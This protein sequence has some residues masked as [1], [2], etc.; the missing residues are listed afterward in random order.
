MSLH[1]RAAQI[2]KEIREEVKQGRD[3]R[4]PH[5][6]YDLDPTVSA[7][8]ASMATW[9]SDLEA[10]IAKKTAPKK[11]MTQTDCDLA[12]MTEERD[13]YAQMY[14]ATEVDL[15]KVKEELDV[16]TTEW[17]NHLRQIQVEKYEWKKKAEAYVTQRD[18][19]RRDLLLYTNVSREKEQRLKRAI[20]EYINKARG[21][22]EGTD[23]DDSLASED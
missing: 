6:Q 8:I 7:L 5:P 18:V 13:E 23:V 19:A 14:R 9:I 1:E 15:H 4:S 22:L 11:T 20:D 16:R 2:E 10:K 12:R 21:I 3:D 17:N